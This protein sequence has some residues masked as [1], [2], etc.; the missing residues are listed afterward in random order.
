MALSDEQ[1]AEVVR[2]LRA[3]DAQQVE[4]DEHGE[5]E[6]AWFHMRDSVEDALGVPPGT[7]DTSEDGE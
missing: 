5:R 3:M 1:L 7:L 4:T 6:I 2:V